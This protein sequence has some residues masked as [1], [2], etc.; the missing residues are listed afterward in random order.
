MTSGGKRIGS[1]RHAVAE[2]EKRVQISISVSPET[3]RLISEL[4]KKGVKVGPLI[5]ELLRQHF[6]ELK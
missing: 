2:E 6:G 3:K 1:G 4:R 5:D